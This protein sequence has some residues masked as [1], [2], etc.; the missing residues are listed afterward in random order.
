MRTL[1]AL[2]RTSP[3]TISCS[4]TSLELTSN[5]FRV[6]PTRRQN[7]TRCSAHSRQPSHLLSLSRS[8]LFRLRRR[9]CPRRALLNL[10]PLGG[11][12]TTVWFSFPRPRQS[13]LGF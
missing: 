7:S 9:S 4:T 5:S 11:R 1:F 13:F 8:L 12:Q 2:R 6:S 3:S 10:L